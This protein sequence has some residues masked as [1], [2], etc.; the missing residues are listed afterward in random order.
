[1][2]ND[3]EREQV[4]RAVFGDGWEC[5]KNLGPYVEGLAKELEEARK[6]IAFFQEYNHDLVEKWRFLIKECS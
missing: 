4:A 6:L 3:G 5:C 2:W 1:M